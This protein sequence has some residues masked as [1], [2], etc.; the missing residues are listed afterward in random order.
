[1]LLL[2]C[3]GVCGWGWGWGWAIVYTCTL[4]KVI[5]SGWWNSRVKCESA[6]CNELEQEFLLISI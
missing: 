2:L 6:G 3:D 1:M 5:V 4:S